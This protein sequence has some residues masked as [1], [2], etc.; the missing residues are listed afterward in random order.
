M[1][2]FRDILFLNLH[3]VGI[4]ASKPK[5]NIR[6]PNILRFGW[7]SNFRVLNVQASSALRHRW[8]SGS[9]NLAAR[10]SL[11]T[12]RSSSA[13]KRASFGSPCTGTSA[14]ASRR[15]QRKSYYFPSATGLSKARVRRT[16]GDG[17]SGMSCSYCR[18]V[19]HYSSSER[20][21][22][23][24]SIGAVCICTDGSRCGR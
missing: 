21:T 3:T 13:C 5:I 18:I 4:V 22:I 24:P 12:D 11:G 9:H 23:Y 7:V 1:C 6:H 16:R 19:I 8:S 10:R 20:E 15:L 2:L 17:T 14:C